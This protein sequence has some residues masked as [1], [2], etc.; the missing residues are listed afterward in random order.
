MALMVGLLL[1]VGCDGGGGDPPESCGSYSQQTVPIGTAVTVDICFTDPEG[2][3][4]TLTASVE[5]PALATATLAGHLLTITAHQPGNTMVTVVATNTEGL[6]ATVEIPVTVPN[7]PP[8]ATGIPIPPV[9]QVAGTSL[10]KNLSRYAEDPDS[11]EVTWSASSENENILSASVTDNVVTTNAGSA[12]MTTLTLTAMDGAGGTVPFSLPVEV[13]NGSDFDMIDMMTSKGDWEPA[14]DVTS[15]RIDNGEML[16]SGLEPGWIAGVFQEVGI[17]SGDW[18]METMFAIAEEGSSGGIFMAA[19]TT[20]PGAYA[21]LMLIVGPDQADSA[22]FRLM[23]LDEAEATLEILALGQNEELRSGEYLHVGIGT[24]EGEFWYRLGSE[25]TY[26]PD[27]SGS[28]TQT[29]LAG[30]MAWP[31]VRMEPA[32]KV[33]IDWFRTAG[34]RQSG[35]HGN[36]TPPRIF[37]QIGSAT[38]PLIGG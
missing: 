37:K 29:E 10:T 33:E 2:G 23:V 19:P 30:L 4:L 34:V 13:F 15:W 5:D 27:L 24:E 7:R 6:S 16:L 26:P 1:S 3:E 22:D 25:V 9:Y 31:S 35:M 14:N 18:S 12:G 17:H 20:L 8:V 28:W 32:G 11:A 21:I 38:H 36:E